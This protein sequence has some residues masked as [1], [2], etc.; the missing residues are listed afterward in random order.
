MRRVLV[1]G[2]GGFVGQHFVREF[3]ELRD[4]GD[5]VIGIERSE[6]AGAC[7]FCETHRLD[8]LNNEGVRT[9]VATLKPTHI[10]HLAALSSLPQAIGTPSNAWRSNF[11]ATLN[12]AEAVAEHCSEAATFLYASTSEIY[13]RSFKSGV[14]VDE[15]TLAQPLSI[16]GRTKYTT[17]LMVA[18]VLP[19]TMRLIILRPFNHT[20][21]GQDERFVLPSFAGQIARMELGLAPPVLEVGDLSPSRDFLDVRDVVIAYSS[22]LLAA[23][24]LA[25]RLIYNIS[26]GTPRKISSVLSELRALARIDFEIRVAADRLRPSE[27]PTAVGNS[28][29]IRAAV[30]W[31]P[32]IPW[33]ETMHSIIDYARK[34][35]AANMT[36]SPA[37][38]NSSD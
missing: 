10:L 5:R 33:A 37:Q 13:G 34:K 12:L 15:N 30:G 26:S 31:E 24:T 38:T 6:I 28:D 2:V 14:A 23:D 21:A 3:A 16:Y 8:L 35:N 20:G 9:L 19:A 17:E 11:V 18:D 25:M 1:T 22:L 32:M 4:V 29:A 36:S 7:N 27:I